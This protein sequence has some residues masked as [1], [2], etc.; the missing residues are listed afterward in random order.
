MSVVASAEEGYLEFLNIKVSL[1]SL[2]CLRL[3]LVWHVAGTLRNQQ[4]TN[5]IFFF[6]FCGRSAVLRPSVHMLPGIGWCGAGLSPFPTACWRLT[7]PAAKPATSK[8]V[9]I[10]TRAR[11]SLS[12]I[13]VLL[14]VYHYMT[15]LVC[16]AVSV[17]L[18]LCLCPSCSGSLFP[19]VCLSLSV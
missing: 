10:R 13:S 9:N 14:R 8:C 18:S 5:N 17:S 19:L 6:F 1:C 16:L 3:C 15:V 2:V 12:V 7:H 11:Y 4:N